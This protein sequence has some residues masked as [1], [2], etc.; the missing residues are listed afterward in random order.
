M[1]VN[2]IEWL[3]QQYYPK[4]EVYC[5]AIEVGGEI[6]TKLAERLRWNGVDA[7]VYSQHGVVSTVIQCKDG[8]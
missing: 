4:A 1:N 2:Y 3:V 5:N 6:P 7:H 8:V